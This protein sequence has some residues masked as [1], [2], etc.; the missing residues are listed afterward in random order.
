MDL[1]FEP[2]KMYTI[3]RLPL[4]DNQKDIAVLLKL[5]GHILPLRHLYKTKRILL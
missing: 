1:L 3:F 4:I 5:W 2:L